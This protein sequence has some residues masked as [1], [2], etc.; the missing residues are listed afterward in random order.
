MPR[1]PSSKISFTLLVGLS[2]LIVSPTLSQDFSICKSLSDNP[3]LIDRLNINQNI[4]IQYQDFLAF[5]DE[6]SARLDR[7]KRKSFTWQSAAQYAGSSGQ[8]DAYYREGERFSEASLER[9]CSTG[10]HRFRQRIA[11]EVSAISGSM[12]GGLFVDC[13]KVLAD[14]NIDAIGGEVEA[15]TRDS[16]KFH[17]TIHRSVRNQG[18]DFYFD[19]ATRGISCVPVGAPSE[20]SRPEDRLVKY[21][22]G[23]LCEAPGASGP[24]NGQL[25]FRGLDHNKQ[26][27]PH[28]KTVRFLVTPKTVE[29]QI[30]EAV[31]R[32]VSLLVEDIKERIER[33]EKRD[34]HVVRCDTSWG[35]DVVQGKREVPF[36]ESECPGIKRLLERPTDW[37]IAAML[38]GTTLCGGFTEYDIKD[39][40]ERKI[41]FTVGSHHAH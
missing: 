37:T 4:D 10:A 23:L 34:V 25:S 9:A 38:V 11:T 32:R 3:H 6:K 7:A 24:I 19:D 28:R 15:D 29:Q 16:T 20:R 18:F 31:E 17:V 27:T 30:A 36:T 41:F 39:L 35:G 12:I 14:A 8:G 1:F 2:S 26:V 40:P 13:L 22:L 33:L 5:C 21:Q